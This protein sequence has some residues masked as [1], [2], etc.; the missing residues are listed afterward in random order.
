MIE[1]THVAEN[2]TWTCHHRAIKCRAGHVYKLKQDGMQRNHMAL[3][4]HDFFR[5]DKCNPSC[6][7]FAVFS[8]TPDRYATCYQV[9]EECWREW[10]TDEPSL[11]TTEML[12]VIRDPAG[13]SH[14]PNF[15]P[16]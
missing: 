8:T 12:Y 6:F 4:G 15:R 7:W 3:S 10:Q 9:S 2:T 5:C 11:P 16:G 14:N 1:S 13:R